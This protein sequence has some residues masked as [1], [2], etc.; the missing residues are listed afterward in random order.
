MGAQN[1]HQATALIC[2]EFTFLNIN[3]NPPNLDKV[4]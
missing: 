4:D 3:Y 1:K 2:H